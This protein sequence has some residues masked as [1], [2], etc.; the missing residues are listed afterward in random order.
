MMTRPALGRPLTVMPNFKPSMKGVGL[1][2]DGSGL[3]APITPKTILQDPGVEMVGAVG[4]TIAG[5]IAAQAVDGGWAWPFYAVSLYGLL[6]TVNQ[7]TDDYTILV[8]TS[9]VG[10]LVALIDF[11]GREGEP[12]RRKRSLKPAVA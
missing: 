7:F 6:R 3:G 5:F 8:G 2:A 9:L 11:I 10:T 4:T 1:G 12:S